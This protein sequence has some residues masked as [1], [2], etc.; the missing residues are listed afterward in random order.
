MATVLTFILECK[1]LIKK[2]ILILFPAVPSK[3][4]S[5]PTETIDWKLQ[6][7]FCR[8]EQNPGLESHSFND[9]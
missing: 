5:G 7:R 4:L 8:S 3:I 2:F 6:C 1:T 9:Y